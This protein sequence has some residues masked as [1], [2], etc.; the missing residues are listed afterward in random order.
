MGD[1]RCVVV[2]FAQHLERNGISL[3]RY[4]ALNPCLSMTFFKEQRHIFPDHAL[5]ALAIEP[6]CFGSTQHAIHIR[7][8][9]QQ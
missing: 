9:A 8:R 4:R 1:D 2:G 3:N 5:A 6:S 7:H